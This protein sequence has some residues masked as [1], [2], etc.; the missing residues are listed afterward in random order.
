MSTP[1]ASA[2]CHGCDTNVVGNHAD[3]QQA[4]GCGHHA[5][6][7]PLLHERG[8][9]GRHEPVERQVDPATAAETTDRDQSLADDTGSSRTP[10]DRRNATAEAGFPAN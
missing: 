4:Q 9:E 6:D 5:P 7:A 2:S 10:V 1:Q 3:R 8:G